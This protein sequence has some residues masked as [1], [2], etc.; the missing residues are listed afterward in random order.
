[1]KIY[2]CNDHDTINPVGGASVIVAKDKQ[3][4]IRK[5]DRQ[6]KE[7]GL[8]GYCEEPYTLDELDISKPQAIILHDGDY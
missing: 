6:L 1:M 5:L 2:T 7:R 4:A 3:H 8:K